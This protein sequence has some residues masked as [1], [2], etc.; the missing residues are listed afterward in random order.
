LHG[1]RTLEIAWTAAPAL[2]L[3]IIAIP[4]VGLIF[5]S[6]GDA[7][8]GALQ[9][10]AIGHQWWFEFQYP[11]QKIVTANEM[12]IPVGQ[13]VRVALQSADVIHSFWV[14]KLAG[15]RDMIPDHTN[16]IAFTPQKTATYFGQCAEFCGISHANMSFRVV[17]DTPAD[18][19]AWVK[20]QQQPPVAPSTAQQQAGA[21]AFQ[22]VT[23]AGCHTIGGTAAPGLNGIRGPDLTH[24]G[25]RSTIAAGL[26]PNTPAD[27]DRWLANPQEVKP[28]NL[29]AKVVAPGMLSQQQIQ[30][31]TAYLESLK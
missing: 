14:P 5:Q 12:H 3:T 21:K 4:T 10:T 27:L 24:I 8:A 9:V 15:K 18:F 11:D 17:V 31:L 6:S 23:C 30:D 7:P 29:M 26:L 22:Q 1:H 13:P 16:Y 20:A 19:A 25:D 28:G 2:I